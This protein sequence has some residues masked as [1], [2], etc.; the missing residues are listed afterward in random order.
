M[1]GLEAQE[2]S[3]TAWR[4]KSGVL[5]GLEKGVLKFLAG[6]AE[7]PSNFLK[8]VAWRRRRG[9]LFAEEEEGFICD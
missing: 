4:V 7:Q 3:S 9:A 8:D 2:G 5:A 1:G 6:S